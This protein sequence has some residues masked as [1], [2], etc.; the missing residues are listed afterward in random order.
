MHANGID[1]RK[2]HIRGPNWQKIGSNVT[3]NVNKYLRYTFL[4][5]IYIYL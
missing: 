4:I 5:P 2:I 3:F 1:S